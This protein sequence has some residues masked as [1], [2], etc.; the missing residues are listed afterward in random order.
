MK[1]NV[2]LW[3]LILGFVSFGCDDDDD[4]S[5]DLTASIISGTV[6]S[7]TWR[8]SFYKDR[9]DDETSN[10]AGYSFAFASAGI[11]VA[12]KSGVDTEGAWSSSESDGK[13]KLV[14]TFFPTDPFDELSEDWEV[15]KRTD[16]SIELKH[17]SGGDGHVDY[18]TFQKN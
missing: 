11:V 12:T 2:F 14:L 5:S 6:T 3:I 8:V 13:V 16:S 18:L 7:G 4:D 1:L 9:D 17:V 15:I 10:Y